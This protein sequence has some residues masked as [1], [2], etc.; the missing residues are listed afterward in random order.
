MKK[1][2]FFI[3]SIATIYFSYAW[4][5]AHGDKACDFGLATAA[6]FTFAWLTGLFFIG[7]DI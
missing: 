7:G 3:F 4:C 2:P 5:F 6:S 1:I